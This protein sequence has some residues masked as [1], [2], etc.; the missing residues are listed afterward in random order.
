MAAVQGNCAT[1]SSPVAITPDELGEAW[2]RGRVNLSLQTQWNG[3]KLGQ[4]EAGS[5]M[6]SHFGQL[7]ALLARTRPVRAGSIL[8]A[9]PVSNT[10]LEKRGQ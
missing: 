8:G 1:A 6:G 10:G 7:L 2:A 4:C 5:D 3:R 9:G